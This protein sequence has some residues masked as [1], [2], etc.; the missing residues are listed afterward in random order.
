MKKVETF[1]SE[2]RIPKSK[3]APKRVVCHICHG[4]GVKEKPNGETFDCPNRSCNN[5]FI[6]IKN[7]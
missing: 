7:K 6:I 1:G 3:P 2:Q 4:M 5:G